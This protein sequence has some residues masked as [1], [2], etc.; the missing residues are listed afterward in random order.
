MDPALSLHLWIITLRFK[1]LS[2][3]VWLG[4][5]PRRFNCC[6]AKKWLTENGKSSCTISFNPHNNPAGNYYYPHLIDKETKAARKVKLLSQDPELVQGRAQTWTQVTYFICTSCGLFLQWQSSFRSFLRKEE[7]G[8][9]YLVRGSENSGETGWM[10]AVA[11][12]TALTHW[13]L[14]LGHGRTL[15]IFPYLVKYAF[16]HLFWVGPLLLVYI[17]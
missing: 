11:G 1:T 16:R 15:I 17:V 3:C 8:G 7:A 13:L 5:R 2:R 9:F 12:Q 10:G 4:H 6:A 14:R